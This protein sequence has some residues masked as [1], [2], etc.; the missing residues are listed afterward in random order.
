MLQ[1]QTK[2]LIKDNSGLLQGKI[3]NISGTRK[4]KVG[5]KLKVTIMRAKLKNNM[6]KNVKPGKLPVLRGKLQD[7]LVIQT[8]KKINRYDGSSLKFNSNCGVCVNLSKKRLQFGFKRINTCVPFELKNNKHWQ[9]FKG[10]YNLMKLAK[11]F[12]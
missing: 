9:A 7:L 8:K 11:N 4:A 5:N 2:I 3:I 1:N 6:G 12:I 10:S